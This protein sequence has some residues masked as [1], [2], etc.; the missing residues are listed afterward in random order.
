MSAEARFGASGEADPEGASAD[1]AFQR[2]EQRRTPSK[3]RQ[4]NKPWRR[5][6]DR[7]GKLKR[8]ASCEMCG[9]C[10]WVNWTRA[11]PCLW[12]DQYADESKARPVKEGQSAEQSAAIVEGGAGD[13]GK[14]IGDGGVRAEVRS[15][16]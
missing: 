2:D 8:P 13:E 14:G 15:E 4:L 1:P 5:R 11:R 9:R 7:W 12:C 10:L 16:L 3:P 6:R